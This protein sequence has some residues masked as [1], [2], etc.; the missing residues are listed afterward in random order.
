MIYYSVVRMSLV[1]DAAKTLANT[2]HNTI[3]LNWR[4]F[5]EKASSIKTVSNSLFLTKGEIAL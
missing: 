1:S 3:R 4:L 2:V 5:I